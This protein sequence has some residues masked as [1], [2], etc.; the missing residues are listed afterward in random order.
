MT[1]STASKVRSVHVRA[2]DVVCMDADKL[3]TDRFRPTDSS[4]S[5]GMVFV[6]SGMPSLRVTWRRYTSF[7][8]AFLSRTCM[9]LYSPSGRTSNLVTM[10][11]RHRPPPLKLGSLDAIPRNV[12]VWHG[13]L[14]AALQESLCSN[15]TTPAA[16]LLAVTK[17]QSFQLFLKSCC[18][19]KKRLR[20]SDGV[21]LCL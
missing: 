17:H 20:R 19:C 1:T 15:R 3:D 16:S 2:K 8:L 12:K 11:K 7:H 5:E 4:L 21:T 13:P 10:V 14:A 9:S 6:S 18:T